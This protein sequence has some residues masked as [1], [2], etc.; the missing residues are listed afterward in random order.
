MQQEI[1]NNIKLAVGLGVAGLFIPEPLLGSEWLDKHFY[2]SAESSSIEGRWI[3]YPYQIGIANWMGNDDIEV[4]DVQKSARVGYTKIVIGI[5]GYFIEHKKRKGLIYQ[6]TTSDAMDFVKDEINP[7]LRDVQVLR[8]ELLC[9]PDK[10]SPHNTNEKKTF[11]HSILDIKGGGTGRNYRRMTKD[12]VIYDEL[13][14]FEQDIDREGSPTSLGDTRLET[15][16]SPKSIRGTTP[17][18]AGMSHI[19]TSIQGAEMIMRRYLPCPHCGN[20]DFLKWANCIFDSK[21]LDQAEFK[22]EHC[23]QLYNYS[24]YPDM[25]KAGKWMTDTGEYYNEK[26][27]RFYSNNHE[28]IPHPWHIGVYIWSAYSYS[29]GWTHLAREFLA[30]DRK[31]KE[32]D[33]TKMKTFVN[34][35]LGETW[36]ES[37]E[38]VE[39]GLFDDRLE[40]FPEDAIP[41]D[42]LVISMGVDIQG[43]K[44]DPRVEYE[45]VGWGIGEESWS[46]EYG[47]IKGDF[48]HQFPKDHLDDVLRTKYTRE[49]GVPLPITCAFIDSG[50]KTES[51]YEYTT[52]RRQRHVYAIK[53]SSVTH[54]QVLSKPSLV[55]PN[56]KTTLYSIGTD[57]AKEIIY[58]RL[59]M[60]DHGPGYCHFPDDREPHY[61]AMLTAE[62]RK[63]KITRGKKSFYFQK[64]K[65]HMPNEALDCR[66]YAYAALK[67]INPNLERLKQR[68]HN[69]AEAMKHGQT[70]KRR[71]G[72]RVLSKGVS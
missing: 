22:C 41:N 43:G 31:K 53:G 50:H 64:K 19:E 67:R 58:T 38:S 12:F 55:G 65:D 59:E 30:A 61:F 11:R 62:E 27:D 51:V 49:D 17:K 28:V 36:Q 33:L 40:A 44:K 60:Q 1:L 66:V 34:T 69:H 46:L 15:S 32:G 29:K 21:D 48:D 26:E 68:L 7:M 45:V 9:D 8:D 13:D 25:D 14:G 24:D 20:M 54:T 71:T 47:V 42:V 23:E 37:G 4:V 39:P 6:P 3:C 52:P 35:R 10:K 16:S 70:P 5:S 56:K 18:I 63:V 72:R 2:L 57:T